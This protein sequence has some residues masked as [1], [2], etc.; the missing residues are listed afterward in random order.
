MHRNI[1][2]ITKDMQERDRL[3]ALLESGDLSDVQDRTTRSSIEALENRIDERIGGDDNIKAMAENRMEY[4][5]AREQGRNIAGSMADIVRGKNSLA[6]RNELDVYGAPLVI[7]LEKYRQFNMDMGE[8]EQEH[9]AGAYDL[10]AYMFAK[11]TL[12]KDAYMDT[13]SPGDK[14]KFKKFWDLRE[15]AEELGSEDLGGDDMVLMEAIQAAHDR[16]K[17]KDREYTAAEAAKFKKAHELAQSTAVVSISSINGERTAADVRA[18]TL[19]KVKSV[20]GREMRRMIALEQSLSEDL[21]DKFNESGLRKEFVNG[22]DAKEA[23]EHIQGSKDHVFSNE[24]VLS[25]LAGLDV[26]NYGEMIGK[27]H[28]AGISSN[29][30]LD[31]LNHQIGVTSAK[32]DS[33]EKAQQLRLLAGARDKVREHSM[34]SDGAAGGMYRLIVTMNNLIGVITRQQE[35][36]N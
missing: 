8:F 7:G 18:E 35:A 25:K 32:K 33:D 6:T 2:D 30:I 16:G 21:K 15:R 22:T 23:W 17:I 12:S 11:S 34:T 10:Q 14:T 19:E 5:R 24:S 1:R 26:E 9:G 3:S 28:G 31:Q 20:E 13:L 29:E 4:I 27:F 36:N